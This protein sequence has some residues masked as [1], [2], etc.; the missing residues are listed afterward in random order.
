M[1]WALH[2]TIGGVIYIH[3]SL[4]NNEDTC[5][6]C[7]TMMSRKWSNKLVFTRS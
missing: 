1:L 5:F 6:L 2:S 4:I 3:L 7:V